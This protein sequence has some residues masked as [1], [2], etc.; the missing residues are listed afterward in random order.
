MVLVRPSPCLDTHHVLETMTGGAVETTSGQEGWQGLTEAGP[1]GGGRR[2][3]RIVLA[4]AALAVTSMVG[5]AGA[6]SG[7]ECTGAFL[8]LRVCGVTPTPVSTPPTTAAPVLSLP[9]VTLPPVTV[10][11][12][13]A[14]PP[15]APL[16]APDAAGRLLDLVNGE[17][18]K[19]GLGQVTSR[20]DITAIALAHSERMAQAGDIFHSDSFFGSAVKALLKAG[21]RGENVAYN[22]D[23][24]SAHARLMASPGHRANIL[25][26][27]FT[28]AGFGVVRHGDGRYFITQDFIQANGAPSPAA[29]P[30][31]AAPAASRSAAPAKAAAPKVAPPKPTPPST[32]AAPTTT[33]APAPVADAVAGRDAG[34]LG[35]APSFPTLNASVAG[36]AASELPL[37]RTGALT[38]SAAG[39]AVAL[40]ALIV[41]ACW[42]IPRRLAG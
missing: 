2:I 34:V 16:S 22:G 9:P 40:I 17:R 18:Q 42:V 25:D 15:P 32:T 26:G 31:Q 14:P 37:R 20:G 3:G 7:A 10:P 13:V 4:G 21:A 35:Q 39:A 19:A 5:T 11:P 29:Q 41:S 12:V 6:A 38:G 28:A 1:R 8:F 30:R 23:I 24:D 36:A 33:T 27:R